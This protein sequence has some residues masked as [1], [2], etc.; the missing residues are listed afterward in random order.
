MT[1]TYVVLKVS[2]TAYDEIRQR[3]I[4][5]D[6]QC[7]FNGVTIDMHGLAIEPED[8]WDKQF[9]SGKLYY[10]DGTEFKQ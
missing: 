8:L 7:Q 9:P 1:Y 5:A 10:S 3:L 6:Y 2:Q 4:E